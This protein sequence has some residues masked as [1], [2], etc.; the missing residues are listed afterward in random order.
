MVYGDGLAELS[1]VFHCRRRS[2]ESEGGG[3]HGGGVLALV[4]D[5]LQ[6]VVK[7]GD[8]FR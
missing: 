5:P 7:A 2:G 6:L 3:G 8:D 1:G 4:D